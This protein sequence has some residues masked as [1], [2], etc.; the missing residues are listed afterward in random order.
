MH[1]VIG[2]EQNNYHLNTFSKISSLNTQFSFE[3]NGFS[4]EIHIFP[5]AI[6]VSA[7]MQSLSPVLELLGMVPSGCGNNNAIKIPA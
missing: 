4:V 1:Q 7:H 5:I 3:L 2:E 6:H